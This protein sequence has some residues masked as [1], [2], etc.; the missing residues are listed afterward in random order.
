MPTPMMT[1]A[2]HWMDHYLTGVVLLHTLLGYDVAVKFKSPPAPET[3][4]QLL[5]DVAGGRYEPAKYFEPGPKPGLTLTT[6]LPAV[7]I[8][9]T[10]LLIGLNVATP[11]S[12]LVSIDAGGVVFEEPVWAILA[13][14]ALSGKGPEEKVA[15]PKAASPLDLWKNIRVAAEAI[16]AGTYKPSQFF[17]PVEGFIA[18]AAG[19]KFEL[20]AV[21]AAKVELLR[22]KSAQALRVSVPPKYF[23]MYT[24]R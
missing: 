9:K 18:P 11:R 12:Q 3:L 19:P 4:I 6:G 7:A 8:D 13:A 15:I 10:Y 20:Y 2:E 24:S 17:A 21:E 14:H 16:Q 22:W 23:E 5:Q 1:L